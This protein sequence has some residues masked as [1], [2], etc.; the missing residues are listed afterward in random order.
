MPTLVV[1]LLEERNDTTFDA[2]DRFER[3]SFHSF[4]FICQKT[5]KYLYK[6]TYSVIHKIKI[7]HS[8]TV[9]NDEDLR[10]MNMWPVT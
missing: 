2:F 7:L 5:I 4:H 10:K 9:N 6:H 1:A 8:F 3:Y